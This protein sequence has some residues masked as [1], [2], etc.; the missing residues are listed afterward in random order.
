MRSA[1]SPWAFVPLAALILL[2]A[3]ILLWFANGAIATQTAAA[4]Q[5]V[6][7]AYRGQLR[8]VRPRID[9]HWR[10]HAAALDATGT[11][12]DIFRRAVEN[13]D[14]AVVVDDN[15]DVVFP[16]RTARRTE[17][18]LMLEAQIGA[19]DTRPPDAGG[20]IERIA[21][22][23]NDYREPLH[24]VERL[25]LM[26]EL[27]QRA[28]N[29]RLPPEAALRLSIE[30]VKAGRPLRE[31][32]LLRPTAIADVWA[33]TSAN[34]RVIALYGTGRLEAM[35]H[36]FLH[37]V[38]PSGIRFIAF[39]PDVP[40]D[41]EAIAAGS[42][43]PGWQLSFQPLDMRP[44]E[45]AARREL[46]AYASAAGGGIALIA[47]VGIVAGRAYGHQL[48]LARLKTD[49]TAAVSHELRTPLAS[50]QVLVDGLLDD[51]RPEPAKTRE[52][53]AMIAGENARLM[54][55]IENF[56]T[57]SRLERGT[58]PM[59]AV[60]PSALV[61]A[62]VA[63]IRDRLPAGCDLRV[64]VEPNLPPVMA[65]ASAIETALVNL[66]DNAVK[67]TPADKRIMLRACRDDA[68][69]SFL[70]QDNGIGIPRHEQRRI[71]RRFYRTDRR[72]SRDTGGVGL[73]LSIV[74]LIA[75][76]HGGRVSVHSEPGAGS[77]FTLRVPCA[78]EGVA[79]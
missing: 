67:Y 79:A 29:V 52:Y 53:L 26:T 38:T 73:G 17:P 15:G 56:L 51:D 7:D 9:T 18:G 28:R 43:L 20:A 19:L 4:R 3:A 46:I 24:A 2:P 74:E 66:L 11:P 49:L 65:A 6:L 68:F 50:I 57:F 39:P 71:F 13:A 58:F 59:T 27:R 40:A 23:L 36:D 41:R 61:A 72:L 34:R 62:A 44:F 33:L 8:L 16:M 48:R 21:A 42:W 55:L 64:D 47:I 22:R 77:T 75:R 76:A 31:P 32:G 37:E 78:S 30:F 1:P 45:A 54:R 63:A 14:G 35:M 69:V 5:R 25:N 60:E 10:V 70:V 12:E